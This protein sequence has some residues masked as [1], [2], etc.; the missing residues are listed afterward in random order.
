MKIFERT[1]NKNNLFSTVF[2]IKKNPENWQNWQCLH[3]ETPYLQNERNRA[4]VQKRITQYINVYLDNIEGSSFI[5]DFENIYIFCKDLPLFQ[6][7]DI[8][9]HIVDMIYQETDHT[10]EF[11]LYDLYQETSAF[12]RDY[13]F[14]ALDITEKEQENKH[15]IEALS[16]TEPKTKPLKSSE[17]RVLLVDD[18]PVTRWLV[19]AALQDDCTITTAATAEKALILFETLCPDIVFLD[20]QLPDGDGHELLNKFLA[21]NSNAYIVMFSGH[22]SL[23]NIVSLLEDG[24][25]G[26]ISKPFKKEKM[27]HHIHKCSS[28]G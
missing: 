22:D 6:L 20:I 16:A 28:K 5:C 8:G 11:Q 4:E 7:K 2:S 12:L 27:L 19:K 14:E 23:R 9:R 25:Q 3:I 15:H 21:L 17:K 13:Q 24:A 26:F 1:E 10:A 18:D